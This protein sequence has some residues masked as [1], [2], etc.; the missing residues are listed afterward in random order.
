MST[1]NLQSV[2]F[3]LDKIKEKENLTTDV[4]L[5]EFLGRKPG[6]ISAWR[7][8]ETLDWELILTKC[9]GYVN[10][11]LYGKGAE[12][13]E[14]RINDPQEEY[15]KIPE[16][17]HEKFTVDLI[18]KIEESPFSQSAK[19]RIIDSLIRILEEDLKEK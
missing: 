13:L 19:I 16:V 10:E 18:R 2:D 12:A 14:I 4:E 8:R 1:R 6:T 11:L 3:I 15:R 5:A 17:K 7:T 9:S